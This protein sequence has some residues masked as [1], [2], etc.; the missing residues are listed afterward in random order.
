MHAFHGPNVTEDDFRIA[1]ATGEP[2]CVDRLLSC[3]KITWDPSYFIEKFGDEECLI[4][5]CEHE[6]QTL[7]TVAEFFGR[8]GNP[9]RDMKI[10]KLKV[11]MILSG[12]YCQS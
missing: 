2:L 9:A 1:W 3:F 7:S 12:L 10:E 11:L 4:V 5:D 8:F 6:T